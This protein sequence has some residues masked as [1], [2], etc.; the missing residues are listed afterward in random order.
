MWFC[1]L[2]KG[3]SPKICILCVRVIINKRSFEPFL[4]LDLLFFLLLLL[5]FF[6]C[7][8]EAE[9]RWGGGGGRWYGEG[10]ARGDRAGGRG[11]GR[12]LYFIFWSSFFFC[13]PFSP[14]IS[15]DDVPGEISRPHHHHHHI[16]CRL[17][18]RHK[19]HSQRNQLSA[20]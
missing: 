2:T 9:E 7:L 15:V 5:F 17:L 3:I 20:N 10:L 19:A 8:S 12:L 11:G 16:V 14:P 6:V 4:C 1:S 13:A 18:S